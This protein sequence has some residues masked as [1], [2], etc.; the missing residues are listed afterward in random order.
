MT[1]TARVLLYDEPVDYH[2][3]K[4]HQV[5]FFVAN[6]FDSVPSKKFLTETFFVIENFL[7]QLHVIWV[8]ISCYPI[9]T[10]EVCVL[11]FVEPIPTIISPLIIFTP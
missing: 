8:T 3:W 5:L 9:N 11:T 10:E 2:C 1:V 4:H 6:R 7:F